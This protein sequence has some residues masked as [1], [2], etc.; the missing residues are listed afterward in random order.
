[1]MLTSRATCLPS[2]NS[3]APHLAQCAV[4]P[5]TDRVTIRPR[6]FRTTRRLP[7]FVDSRRAAEVD[8]SG[9][10]LGVFPLHQPPHH[11]FPHASYAY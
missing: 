1:V 5:P 4:T 9:S 2:T 3:W 10:S 6:R 8:Q 7:I 11:P